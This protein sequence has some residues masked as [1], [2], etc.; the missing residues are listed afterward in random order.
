M[1]RGAA[2][3]QRQGRSGR[4]G[5][6]TRDPRPS[7]R[8]GRRPWRARVGGWLLPDMGSAGVRIRALGAPES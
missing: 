3:E 2:Q 7:R 5:R 6:R 1:R 8:D 4:S